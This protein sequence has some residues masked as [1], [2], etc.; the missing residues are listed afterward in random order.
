VKVQGE[1]EQLAPLNDWNV[2][3]MA[4]VAVSVTLEPSVQLTGPHAPVGKPGGA[5]AQLIRPSLLTTLP[6]PES[7]KLTVSG[8]VAPATPV[9]DSCTLAEPESV[10]IASTALSLATAEG[11]KSTVST[12]APP[13]G[14]AVLQALKFEDWKSVLPE[15]T[16]ES[17]VS[18]DV[19]PVFEMVMLWLRLLLPFCTEPKLSTAGLTVRTGPP[20]TTFFR[21][22]AMMVKPGLAMVT[23]QGE[24]EQPAPFSDCRV[25]PVAGM[26]EIATVAPLV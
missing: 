25:L 10:V 12:H 11:A 8:N 21:K 15:G 1:T 20:A 24:T 23:V 19:V 7:V 2:L 14:M 18:A 5:I 6:E 13:G 17:T 26:A 9:P 3:P 16:A 22:S 4:A